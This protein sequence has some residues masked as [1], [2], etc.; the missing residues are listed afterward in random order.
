M[1]VVMDISRRALDLLLPPQCFSCGAVATE[2]GRLCNVCF[3]DSTFITDPMCACC[4][5]PFEFE[6]EAGRLCGV[7]VAVQ[8][9]YDHVRAAARYEEPIRSAVLSFK[10]GDRT[11]MAPG[12]ATLLERA[13]REILARADI[14]AP[15]PLHPRRLWRRRYNQAALISSELSGRHHL[16]DAPDL[17]LRKRM[18]RSQGGLSATARRRNVRGAFTVNDIYRQ[19]VTGQNVIIIDDVF[20]T[21]ATVEACARALK[22]AGAE[23]VSVLVVARVVRSGQVH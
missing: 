5:L 9:S 4:G 8:P 22:L 15:V 2:P 11:D 14:I 19:A 23:T 17:L 18:T 12:W 1:G 10:H 3:R 20:T 7:C 16:L 13:G 6:V 21:G